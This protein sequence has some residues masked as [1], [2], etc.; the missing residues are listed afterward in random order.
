MTPRVSKKSRK[1]RPRCRL[2]QALPNMNKI[3]TDLKTTL[4]KNKDHPRS[5]TRL[6]LVT[7]ERKPH[8]SGQAKQTSPG[9][10]TKLP[11]EK[12]MNYDKTIT[13]DLHT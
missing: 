3:K 2:D 6:E 1:R 12:R 7:F 5:K 4:N 8:P 10:T 13:T 11:R 9:R